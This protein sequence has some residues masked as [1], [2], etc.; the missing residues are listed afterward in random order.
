MMETNVGFKNEF[1]F[2]K[3]IDVSICYKQKFRKLSNL[4][5]AQ[6]TLAT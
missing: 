4:Y 2:L 3:I 6:C 1:V 5:V